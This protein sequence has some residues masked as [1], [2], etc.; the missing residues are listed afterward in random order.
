MER[1]IEILEDINPDVDYKE[2]TTLME[3]GYLTSFDMVVLVVEIEESFG[4]KIPVENINPDY[5][6][7]VQDIYELIRK[8]KE[9][10]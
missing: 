4:V 10:A 9:E 1:L 3:D 6:N 7:S 5:F 2:C 8:L